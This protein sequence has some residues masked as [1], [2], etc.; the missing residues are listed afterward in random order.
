MLLLGSKLL[1]YPVM[2]LQTGSEIGRTA[3]PII[4]PTSLKVLAYKLD[5]PLLGKSEENTLRTNEVREFSP[6]GLIVDSIDDL[7]NPDDVVKLKEVV[8]LNFK[9]IGHRVET[10][11]GRKLGKVTD[12]TI[13]SSTFTI[14]QLIVKRPILQGFN[15]PELTVNRSQIIEIDD[16][17]VVVKNDK[18]TVKVKQRTKIPEFKPDY[19]N[20]FRKTEQ[21]VESKKV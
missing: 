14:Y 12:F 7:V 4:E 10:K 2:S 21:P 6:I 1:D 8:K 16:Y 15:D 11:K 13:D 18:Q 9:L 17:K 19:V 3:E 20:P 5:G